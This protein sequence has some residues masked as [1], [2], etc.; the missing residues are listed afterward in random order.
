MT[1]PTDSHEVM[2]RLTGS[3]V[4]A[5]EA[6]RDGVGVLAARGVDRESALMAAVE[7]ALLRLID[8]FDLPEPDAETVR[9]GLGS[10][11]ASWSRGNACLT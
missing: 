11:G 7:L 6:V 8:D 10:L 2:L 5:L 4:E 1:M 3:E 9:H